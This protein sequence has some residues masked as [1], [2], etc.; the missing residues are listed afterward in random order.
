MT[1][2]KHGNRTLLTV[3]EYSAISEYDEAAPS[4]DGTTRSAPP[5]V[6]AR[7]LKIFSRGSW[8][9]RSSGFHCTCE[10]AAPFFFPLTKQVRLYNHVCLKDTNLRSYVHQVISLRTGQTCQET[11]Q[12]SQVTL[13]PTRIC[14][15]PKMITLTKIYHSIVETAHDF[16]TATKDIARLGRSVS[17]WGCGNQGVG[18]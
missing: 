1:Q 2:K 18:Q 8:V 16:F 12:H 5:N 9:V 14:I 17:H 11:T 13:T 4:L 7:A 10:R 6:P 15:G 3:S